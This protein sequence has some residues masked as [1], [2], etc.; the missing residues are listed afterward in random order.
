[1]WLRRSRH[2]G[3]N[4]QR[5]L[6]EKSKPCLGSSNLSTTLRNLI[7]L[8]SL[9]IFL[10]YQDA[11]LPKANEGPEPYIGVSALQD[12]DFISVGVVNVDV[13][14]SMILL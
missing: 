7:V 9:L 4:P 1:M 13:E 11:K 2:L 8:I 14:E 3:G 10:P 5:F 12:P 6:Q